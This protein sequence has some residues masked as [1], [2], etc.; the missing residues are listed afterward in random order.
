MCFQIFQLAITFADLQPL[1]GRHLPRRTGG[2]LLRP[3]EGP[4][5]AAAAEPAGTDEHCAVLPTAQAQSVPL[6]R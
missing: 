1:C 2:A 3:P 4:E 6:G 5:G